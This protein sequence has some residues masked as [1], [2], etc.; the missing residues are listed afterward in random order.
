MQHVYLCLVQG[1]LFRREGAIGRY[2]R[3]VRQVGNQRR[4]CLHSAQDEGAHQ[5]SQRDIAAF[6][7]TGEGFEAFS[8]AQQPRIQKFHQAPEFIQ[9]IFHRRAGQGYASFSM[10]GTNGAGTGGACVFNSLGFIQNNGREMQVGQGG[11]ACSHAIRSD[12][13]VAVFPAQVFSGCHGSGEEGCMMRRISSGAKRCASSFQLD[14]R[15]AGATIRAG[16]PS[17]RPFLRNVSSHA[18]A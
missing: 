4:I 14:R 5:A 13:G 8:A 16:R 7:G 18:I 1:G 12:D 11:R 15:E 17:S 2:F 6:Q 10:Q 3:F 9:V